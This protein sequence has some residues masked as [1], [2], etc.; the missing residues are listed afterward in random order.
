MANRQYNYT[1]SL[2]IVLGFL[3]LGLLVVIFAMASVPPVSRDALTHHLAVPKIWL[4][5]G[6][7]TEL[8][9]IPFSYYPMNLDLLYLIPL[10]FG[11]DIVPKYIHGAFAIFTALLIYRQLKKRLDTGFALLGALFFLSIPVI[12]KLSVTVYVDLGLIFFSTA[13]L[14]A[15]LEWMENGYRVKEILLA[16]FCSGLALGTKYNGLITFFLLTCFVPFLYLRKFDDKLVRKM[17]STQAYAVGWMALF[18]IVS[19]VIY[20][21]WM[22]RNAVLTGNPFY[23]LYNGFFKTDRMQSNDLKIGSQTNDTDFKLKQKKTPW[24]N[25]AT[26]KLVYKERLWQIGLIPLRIFFEGEDDNPKHF[27]GKL[28]PF[29]LLLPLLL[30]VPGIGIDRQLSLECVIYIIFSITYLII[31]FFKVDMRTRWIGPII[32]PMVMLSMIGLHRFQRWGVKLRSVRNVKISKVIVG[33]VIG[34]MLVFNVNYIYALYNK[35]DPLNFITGK[36]NRGNY[37][38]KFR[39]EYELMHFINQHLDDRASIL[40]LFIGNRIYYCNREIQTNVKEFKKSVN[41]S[42]SAEQIQTN[43]LDAGITHILLR[44]ELFEL[45]V[46]HDINAEKQKTLKLFF[47]KYAIPLKLCAGYGFFEILNHS[48]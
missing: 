1:I 21:P 23:P 17:I 15:L 36:V 33:I 39:P 48:S 31:V 29:L 18:I 14:F 47:K 38:A 5:K 26:R 22:A 2:N 40:G 12:V 44:F 6:L 25:F 13:A 30:L 32:P 10:S 3:I 28:S 11:N 9:T 34:G 24:K 45:W 8:P 4:K 37:I 41:S 20:S 46:S 19:I 7:F 42:D 43:L 35:I 27:D 16:G